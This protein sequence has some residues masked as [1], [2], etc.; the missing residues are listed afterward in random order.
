VRPH[1]TR[2]VRGA[3]VA[4]VALLG[5]SGEVAAD[6]R[7]KCL[8][9]DGALSIEACSH[10][11]STGELSGREL[12]TIYVLRATI[13]RADQQYNLA[14]QDLTR[15]IELLKASGPADVVSSAYITRASVYSLSNDLQNALA[16]YRSAQAFDARNSQAAEGIKAM[17]AAIAATA[18]KPESSSPP[19][20]PEDEK[21]RIVSELACC[22]AY[23][24]GEVS[25]EGWAPPQRCRVNMQNPVTKNKFCLWLRQYYPARYKALIR[26]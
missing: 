13:Y 3:V 4:I 26:E 14:L 1:F 24:R 23:Y 20:K 19:S 17:E 9:R 12:A 16:D 18:S 11:I 21:E 8:E 25:L 2:H 10:V 7:A 6:D 22:L 5:M 15:A